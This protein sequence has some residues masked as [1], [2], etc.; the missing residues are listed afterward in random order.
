[1]EGDKVPPQTL[2]HKKDIGCLKVTRRKMSHHT[3]HFEK[4]MRDIDITLLKKCR[5]RK[6][7]SDEMLHD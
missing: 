7:C 3:K 1:M 2:E 5:C 6:I 4:S